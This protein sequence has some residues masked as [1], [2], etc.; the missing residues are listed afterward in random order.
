MTEAPSADCWDVVVVG[1][2]MAGLSA[3]VYLGRSRRRTLIID[4]GHSMAKWEPLVENYLA[5]P[6]GISGSAL[7]ERSRT[8][9]ARFG[10]ERAEDEIRDI[11][12]DAQVGGQ[13]PFRLVGRQSVYYGTRVLLATGLTHLLPDIPGAKDCLGH[14]LF[15]CKD[16]DAFRVQGRPVGVVGSRE[17]AARYALAMLAF[18]PSVAIATNGENAAWSPYWD[19]RLQEYGVPVW[20]EQVTEIVHH[21]GHV[22]GLR[23]QSGRSC[24]LEALFVTRGD[25]FHTRLAERLGAQEDKD[26]QLIVDADMKTTVPGLY[27]AGCVT[28]ANCQMIIAAGQ[29]ATA[30]QAINRDLFEEHLARH[31]LPR[32]AS[33]QRAGAGL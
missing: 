11:Q 7:L 16:C 26:G 20:R 14:S 25:V 22:R 9:A 17:D 8:H 33:E 10:T 29:G 19:E 23:W 6:E 24:E 21:Q 31:A 5:F 18:S 13:G 28:P 30:G 3:A 27:A 32:F 4:S 1:G 15:F 2:G 12:R